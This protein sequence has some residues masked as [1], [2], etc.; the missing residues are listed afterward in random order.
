M[1]RPDRDPDDELE[2]DEPVG[3]LLDDEA[4]DDDDDDD[5][6]DDEDVEYDDDNPDAEPGADSEEQNP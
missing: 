1:R 2:E 3:D 6:D 5:W 4:W